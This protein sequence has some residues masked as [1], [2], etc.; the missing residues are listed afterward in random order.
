MNSV[1]GSNMNISVKS[2]L[3]PSGAAHT[4]TGDLYEK[5][6]S[7]SGRL[8]P[9]LYTQWLEPYQDGRTELNY[10][11]ERLNQSYVAE[12][13]QG[14][15]NWNS[16]KVPATLERDHGLSL[17]LY[18]PGMSDWWQLQTAQLPDP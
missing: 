13:I 10:E 9:Q 5:L 7:Q 18:F 16:V 2:E 4:L 12:K 3:S 11:T 8:T 14:V 1:F 17:S 6:N 15:L